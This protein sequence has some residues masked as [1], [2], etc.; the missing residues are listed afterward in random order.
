M[1]SLSHIGV[2]GAGAWG[3]ALALALRRAG[4]NVTLWAR[5]PGLAEHIATTH[6]NGL[7]LP[8]IKLDPAIQTTGNLND[9][10]GCQALILATPAQY[11][12]DTCKELAKFYTGTQPLIIAAKGIELST[13]RLISEVVAAE[14]PGHPVFVLSGPSFAAEVAAHKPTALT[15]ASEAD[16]EIVAHAIASPLLRIYTSDDIIGTQIGGAVK[17]VLAIACGIVAGRQMGENARAALITRGLAEIVRLGVALGARAETITGL[18]GLGDI[19]LSCSSAQS[20]NMSLGIALGQGKKLAD[21][22]AERTCVTEGVAT[23]SATLGLAHRHGVDMPVVKA[24]DRILRE[25]ANIDEM[26]SGL[27]ARPSRAEAA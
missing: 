19:V 10:A 12:R 5:D 18:S 15:L 8:G 23:A 9:M 4:T 27:L 21:I 17:N 3:T 16:C 24:V 6:E 20:R 1:L 7:Y 14:M 11:V 26:I 13:H 22:L 2:I 25:N